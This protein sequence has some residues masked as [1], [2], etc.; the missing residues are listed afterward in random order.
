VSPAWAWVLADP[1][2]HFHHCAEHGH[3]QT[4]E[5]QPHLGP[6]GLLVCTQESY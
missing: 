2:I 4:K 3:C 1:T 5:G 6:E